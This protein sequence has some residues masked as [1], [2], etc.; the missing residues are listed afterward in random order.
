ML[1]A[2]AFVDHMFFGGWNNNHCVTDYP[3]AEAFYREQAA[4]VRRFCEMNGIECEVT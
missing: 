2:V 4:M 1:E 3:G